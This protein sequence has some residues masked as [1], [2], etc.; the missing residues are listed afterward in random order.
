[1]ANDRNNLQAIHVSCNTVKKSLDHVEFVERLE[2]GDLSLS[3]AKTFTPEKIQKLKDELGER[4][5]KGGRIAAEK[6][7]GLWSNTRTNVN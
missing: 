7:I 1:M 6:G 2:S 4:S 5:R 3:P